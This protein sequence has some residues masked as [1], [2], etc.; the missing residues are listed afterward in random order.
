MKSSFFEILEDSSQCVPIHFQKDQYILQFRADSR[1]LGFGEQCSSAPAKAPGPSLASGGWE[2]APGRACFPHS[3]DGSKTQTQHVIHCKRRTRFPVKRLCGVTE[4][5]HSAGSGS[6][7]RGLVRTTQ[8]GLCFCCQVSACLHHLSCTGPLVY[9]RA[10]PQVRPHMP[11]W[12]GALP[13]QR[14][15][16]FC[17]QIVLRPSVCKSQTLQF[18][19]T[20]P[21][22][23]SAHSCSLLLIMSEEGLGR[24][25]LFL[26]PRCPLCSPGACG[27][28]G[29]AHVQPGGVLSCGLSSLWKVTAPW[30]MLELLSHVTRSPGDNSYG[31]GASPFTVLP[32]G[33]LT[34]PVALGQNHFLLLWQRGLRQNRSNKMTRR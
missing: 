23:C 6:Y 8:R 9:C 19:Q 16:H 32:H 7:M 21:S 18:L 28:A 15:M 3:C 14:R 10:C 27:I 17:S 5:V 24:S 33:C 34:G 31:C 30:E 26:W 11:T 13:W 25:C 22:T 1:L 4:S 29:T 12:D 2:G 20:L